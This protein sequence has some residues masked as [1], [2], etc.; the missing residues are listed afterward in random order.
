MTELR[1]YLVY[2]CWLTGATIILVF[3][4]KA[5]VATDVT[6]LNIFNLSVW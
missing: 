6:V 4:S 1:E 5:E 2:V 3:F